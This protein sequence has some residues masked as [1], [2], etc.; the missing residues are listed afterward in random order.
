MILGTRNH[1]K[2][3]KGHDVIINLAALIG[4]P[5][6]YEATK[7]YYDTNLYGTLNLLESARQIKFSALFKHQQAKF[8]A[9]L[10]IP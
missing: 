4:I 6:S 9:V 5:Y 7:S 1:S 2:L 3:S 10:N 8:M